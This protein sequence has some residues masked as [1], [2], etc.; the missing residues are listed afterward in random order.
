VQSAEADTRNPILPTLHHIRAALRVASILDREGAPAGK[1][2]AAYLRIPT[3]GVFRKSDLLAGERL[4]IRSGLL[5]EHEGRLVP[6]G[7]ID[8]LSGLPEGEACS[9]LLASLLEHESPVWL[10]VAVGEDFVADEF[11]PTAD[12]ERLAHIISE[13]RH[14][15]A[16]LLSVAKRYNSESSRVLGDAGEVAVVDS[17]REGLIANGRPDLAAKVRR[18]STISDQLGYDVV[19][20]RIDGGVSRL[21]VKTTGRSG[22]VLR[23]FLSRNEI[24]VGRRDPDWFLVLCARQANGTITVEGWCT[25]ADL[26]SLLPG[27]P[28]VSGL[29]RGRWES[30]R[31]HFPHESLQ[32][33]LP[34]LE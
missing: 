16:L 21:E 10:S 7:S 30:V 14:R 6:V 2:R 22:P 25:A 5:Q 17:C 23:F 26:L 29:A 11:I 1:I 19:A 9:L 4:L 34:G 32:P 12:F 8:D 27:D 33:G 3:D 31:V 15:E 28:E 20:P 24:E 13:P 18:V